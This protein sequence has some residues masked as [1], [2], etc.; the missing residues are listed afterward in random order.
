MSGSGQSRGAIGG[1][2]HHQGS[3]GSDSNNN[4]FTSGDHG[5]WNYVQ[6]LEEKVK[7]LSERVAIMEGFKRDQEE[8]IAMLSNELNSLRNYLSS[9]AQ[10]G[11]APHA[12]QTTNALGAGPLSR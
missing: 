5:V 7:Q 3:G 8:R 11:R 2:P 6:N 4:L 9:P 12:T 1:T 10:I